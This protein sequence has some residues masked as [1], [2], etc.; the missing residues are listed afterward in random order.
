VIARYHEGGEV[1]AAE[2][3]RAE[4]DHNEN[5]QQQSAHGLALLG[6]S[7]RGKQFRQLGDIRSNPPRLVFGEE[8]GCGTAAALVANSAA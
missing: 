3:K 5:L 1:A 6:E 4:R 8:L 7:F 2:A